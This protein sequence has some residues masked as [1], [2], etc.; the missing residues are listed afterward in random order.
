MEKSKKA[1]EII[2]PYQF[3]NKIE[4]RLREEEINKW[5]KAKKV[6]K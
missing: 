3:F 4:K 6:M 1:Y 5:K 2:A